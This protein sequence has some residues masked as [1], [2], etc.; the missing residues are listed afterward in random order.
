MRR[1]IHTSLASEKCVFCSE[2]VSLLFYLELE[3]LVA[4][5]ISMKD[6]C[7]HNCPALICNF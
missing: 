5:A 4:A 2:M 1:A 6:V 3:R 7:S